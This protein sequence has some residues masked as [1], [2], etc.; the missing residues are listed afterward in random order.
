VTGKT[1]SIDF[2]RTAGAV[3]ST[4][5]NQGGVAN[6]AFVAELDATG[7]TLL[8]STYLGG[9]GED[10]GQSI[11]VDASGNAY[12]TGGTES[13]NFPR[14]A[15][16]FQ[17]SYGGTSPNCNLLDQLCGDVF[18]AKLNPLGCTLVYSTYI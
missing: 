7:S 5:R 18:L 14:T 3:Q 8:Y 12:V 15:G 4:L 13:N 17:N 1:K 6:D 16:A 10:T 9:A 2:P 11:A